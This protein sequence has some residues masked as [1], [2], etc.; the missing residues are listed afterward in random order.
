MTTSNENSVSHYFTELDPLGISKPRSY[1]DR[2][3]AAAFPEFK[4]STTTSSTPRPES[5]GPASLTSVTAFPA[6]SDFG[7]TAQ[8]K[9]NPTASSSV[10]V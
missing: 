1:F 2:K 4:T 10:Q 7:S 3:D 5:A 8:S 9:P 6:S